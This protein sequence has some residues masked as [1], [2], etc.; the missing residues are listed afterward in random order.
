MRPQDHPSYNYS[1]HDFI[2]IGITAFDTQVSTGQRFRLMPPTVS[3]PPLKS[4]QLSL[5]HPPEI[6]QSPHFLSPKERYEMSHSTIKTSRCSQ[7]LF[8]V[9]ERSIEVALDPAWHG[10]LIKMIFSDNFDNDV[11]DKIK[12]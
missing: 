8:R 3:Q 5:R 12:M 1:I 10:Q 7:Y 6:A 9:V 11:S 4:P 2:T